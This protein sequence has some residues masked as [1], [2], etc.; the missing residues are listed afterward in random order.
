[1][2][3]EWENVILLSGFWLI[4]C[5]GSFW[6]AVLGCP[7]SRARDRPAVISELRFCL[8][9]T[10]GEEVDSNPHAQGVCGG[11]WLWGHGGEIKDTAGEDQGHCRRGFRDRLV[12]SA[13]PLSLGW[14]ILG[15]CSY[16]EAWSHVFQA[17][18][19]GPTA[20][21]GVHF[22]GSPL[23]SVQNQGSR[24]SGTRLCREVRIPRRVCSRHTGAPL[25]PTAPWL[26]AWRCQ[27]VYTAGW[28]SW[29]ICMWK[30]DLW[31]LSSSGSP[32][33][34][35]YGPHLAQRVL[36]EGT[37]KFHMWSKILTFSSR[38]P[39]PHCQSVCVRGAETHLNMSLWKNIIRQ[40]NW[41]VHIIYFRARYKLLYPHHYTHPLS[42]RVRSCLWHETLLGDFPRE[43]DY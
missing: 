29:W 30:S 12:G 13:A 34:Q 19:H 9:K 16:A 22:G 40:I 33:P 14:A 2:R 11:T 27:A 1:M 36:S 3:R 17:P 24:V 42:C 4:P 31:R 41:K 15:L 21:T 32:P 35:P 18:F 23:T 25:G 43:P 7:P 5:G 10:H 26:L 38:S 28:R 8:G 39:S 20:N 6:A 37:G